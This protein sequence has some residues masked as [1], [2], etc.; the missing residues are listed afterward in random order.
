MPVIL[1]PDEFLQAL[2]AGAEPVR[3]T[4]LGTYPRFELTDGRIL[5]PAD[6]E[7]LRQQGLLDWE[8]SEGGSGQAIRLQL[9]EAGRER[10][11]KG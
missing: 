4:N 6:A 9:T 2:A 10:A 11:R 8:T 7:A 5:D 1:T 3:S